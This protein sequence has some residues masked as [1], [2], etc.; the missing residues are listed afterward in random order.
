[1]ANG[2]RPY[3]RYDCYSVTAKPVTIDVDGEPVVVP[4]GGFICQVVTD[5][6]RDSGYPNSEYA[7]WSTWARDRAIF[8][9]LI[10]RSRRGVL[11]DVTVT[12]DGEVLR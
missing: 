4:I 11:H 9:R 1:M 12:L 6:N 2:R 7:G 8:D 10:G 3:T 5:D